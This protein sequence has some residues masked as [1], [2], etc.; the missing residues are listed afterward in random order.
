MLQKKSQRELLS[1]D[2]EE[3][4]ED[5]ERGKGKGESILAVVAGVIARQHGR[6]RVGAA[7]GAFCDGF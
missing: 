7:G 4:E 2:E 5:L 3:E 6:E 1:E